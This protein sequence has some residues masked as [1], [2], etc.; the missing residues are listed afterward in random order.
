MVLWQNVVLCKGTLLRMRLAVVR[1]MCYVA[2]GC[3]TQRNTLRTPQ[4]GTF[5]TTYPYTTRHAAIAP[6]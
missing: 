6:F 1:V 5:S 2:R 3:H 4:P